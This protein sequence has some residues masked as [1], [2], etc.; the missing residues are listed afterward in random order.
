MLGSV[1][2]VLIAGYWVHSRT[3]LDLAALYL[4][5]SRYWYAAGWNWRA[6]IAT[7]AGGLLAVGGA[8]T[9]AGTSGPFPASGLIPAFKGLY[10]YS[11]VVGLAVGFAVYLALSQPRSLPLPASPQRG[12]LP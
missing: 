10:D 4:R 8:Y 1:A 2:G 9:T 7:L 6:V 3:H 11:W 12:E 5:G